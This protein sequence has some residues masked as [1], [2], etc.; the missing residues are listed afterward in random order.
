MLGDAGFGKRFSM[1]KVSV[2]GLGYVGLPVAV[3][4]G[5]K[6]EV[7]GFDINPQRIQELQSG[8][9]RTGEVSDSELA[10]TRIR[11]TSDIAELKRADFHIVAVPTPVDEANQPDLT[12]VLRAS[13]TVGHALKR[14][15]IVVYESTVYPGATE[16]DCVPVLERVSG[17]KCGRDFFVGY[18]PERI[19]PGDKAHRFT[20][21]KKV[22]SGQTP[23][24]LAIVAETYASVVEAGVHQAASIKVA[25]AAKVIENTQRDLNIALMNELALIFDRLGIDTQAVLEAAGTKWNFLPFRPG[26]VGGHCIGVDPYYLTHKAEKIG[27]IP[28]VILAGRR[29]N[30]SMGRF[31]AQRTIKELVRAGHELRGA[32]V[33]V[34]GLTFKED[35]PDLRNSKV[36]NILKELRDFDV[37]LQVSDPLADPKEAEHEYGV[38]LMAFE[39]LKPA[40]ALIAAVAH[41][42]YRRLGTPE[43]VRL[44]KKPPLVMDV[45]GIFPRAA[46]EAAGI[47]VWRL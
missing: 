10:Q 15:D 39:K 44:L 5:R 19:N 36:A 28:Q 17:L 16:E 42:Q 1:R 40:D 2:V 3:A 26:L 24:V 32:T 33:T 22:V 46:L 31:V 37:E 8:R 21:I 29:I 23:E 45:K 7:I 13:E 25:E 20:T 47:R 4:F 18:S 12:P 14:G 41:Q 34:L 38:K 43:L 9:D 30:D 35:C 6:A 11:F 27:Y